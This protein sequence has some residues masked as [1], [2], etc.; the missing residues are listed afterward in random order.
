[1]T[2][3]QKNEIYDEMSRVLINFENGDD[4]NCDTVADDLYNFVV[5]I[6]NN[7]DELTSEE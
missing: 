1:M 5:K 7:W 6:Q 2:K 3:Q 4:S